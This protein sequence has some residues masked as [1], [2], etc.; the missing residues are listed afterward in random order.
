MR[1]VLAAK[2]QRS[3]MVTRVALCACTSFTSWL[4]WLMDDQGFFDTVDWEAK[5]EA[6][7]KKIAE[8]DSLINR[9]EEAARRKD[10]KIDKLTGIIR[11]LIEDTETYCLRIRTLENVWSAYSKRKE[12][13]ESA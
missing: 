4:N 8:K 9:L 11:P 3:P 10:R 13:K 5:I 12:T 1:L 2:V 7:E 6:C